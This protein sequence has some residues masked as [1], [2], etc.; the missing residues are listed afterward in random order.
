MA[1]PKEPLSEIENSERENE[2]ISISSG[3]NSC[4]TGS[5]WTSCAGN[6]FLPWAGIPP[7][8]DHVTQLSDVVVAAPRG[9]RSSI[10]IGN[11]VPAGLIPLGNSRVYFHCSFVWLVEKSYRKNY[12][13]THNHH[14]VIKTIQCMLGLLG[15]YLLHEKNREPPFFK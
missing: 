7:R 14:W 6:S 3:K 13:K 4:E 15:K 1:G 2:I 11:P 12:F 9:R 5:R 8:Y 10:S